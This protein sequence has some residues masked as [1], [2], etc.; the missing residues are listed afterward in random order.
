MTQLDSNKT[1][2]YN[3]VEVKVTGRTASK[4]VEKVNRLKRRTEGSET[5]TQVLHEVTPSNKEDGSWKK[6]VDLSE[7]HTIDVGQ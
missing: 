3:S 6:W 4:E 5:I 2:I 7:L 1:Y